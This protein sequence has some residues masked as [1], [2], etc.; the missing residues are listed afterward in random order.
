M[1]KRQILQCKIESIY[2]VILNKTDN[3]VHIIY[4]SLVSYYLEMP[5][6]LIFQGI[7]LG[8]AKFQVSF[9]DCYL[10]YLLYLAFHYKSELVLFY[11]VLLYFIF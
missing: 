10:A 8:Y 11:F 7:H 3:V 2:K 5:A 4:T 9:S 6:C 1:S